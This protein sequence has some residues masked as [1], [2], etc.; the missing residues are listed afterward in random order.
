MFS[1]HSEWV[2]PGSVRAKQFSFGER[3]TQLDATFPPSI[4]YNQN[5][6]PT[7]QQRQALSDAFERGF[8][9]S[10]YQYVFTKSIMNACNRRLSC[11]PLF[12]LRLALI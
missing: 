12:D 2:V 11:V 7:S 10:G 1:D 9:F 3:L 6:P 8:S 5:P 4:R